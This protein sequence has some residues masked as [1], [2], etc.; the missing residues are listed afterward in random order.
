[1]KK[2]GKETGKK[3]VKTIPDVDF[4]GLCTE[5]SQAL[6]MDIGFDGIFK[7]LNS[8]LNVARSLDDIEYFCSTEYDT[9]RRKKKRVWSEEVVEFLKE[10]MLYSKG[11]K[12]DRYSVGFAH[13][14]LLSL[15]GLD[16]C[17]KSGADVNHIVRDAFSYF[18]D[19]KKN[20]QDKGVA[21]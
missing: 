17:R 7:C 14:L 1:M 6:D 9:W 10:R 4:E 19:M 5:V 13:L 18:S 2:N 11:A 15:A 12:N 8:E 3:N 21:L 20:M 16:G